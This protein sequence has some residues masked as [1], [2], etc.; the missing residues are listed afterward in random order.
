M[1]F[2]K[3]KFN[4]NLKLIEDCFNDQK[5]SKVWELLQENQKAP[6][7]FDLVDITIHKYLNNS[8]HSSFYSK[9]FFWISSYEMEDTQY[10]SNFLNYYLS[11]SAEF[12]FISNEYKDLVNNS[13]NNLNSSKLPLEIKFDLI[14]NNSNF[15]QNLILINQNKNLNIS[16]THSAFFE[17]KNNKFLIYPQ[18]TA[19]SLFIIN[20]PFKLY[21]RYRMQ[22][23]SHQ[24]GLNHLAGEVNNTNL[25]SYKYKLYENRQSWS[26]N[27]KSWLD[28]NVQNTFRGKV[29]NFI[30]LTKNPEDVLTQIIYHLKQSGLDLNVNF[31]LVEKFTKENPIPHMPDFEMSNQ[32]LKQVSNLLDQSIIEE[33]KFNN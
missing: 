12:A 32:E 4:Y 18:S 13:F 8:N 3:I 10:I 16:F 30:D 11:E 14:V 31:D 19:C 20:N 29:I 26:I 25:D 5:Y 24:E 27:S 2:N 7:Y 28:E 22:G 15:Y 1:I 6:Y 21:N 17:G 33:Y 23:A 9:K